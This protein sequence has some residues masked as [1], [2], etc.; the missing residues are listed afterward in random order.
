MQGMD[1]HPGTY[2][3][4]LDI[5]AVVGPDT[6]GHD[7]F[8]IEVHLAQAV[9]PEE[10]IVSSAF[11]AEPD[12]GGARLYWGHFTELGLTGAV[13]LYRKDPVT[14]VYTRLNSAPLE[15]GSEYLDADLEPGVLY[16]YKLGIISDGS[17]F[18]IGP[19]SVS[20]APRTAHL[21]QNVPNP[22]RTS[23]SISFQ[24]PAPSHVSLKIY[25]VG[26]RLVRT[27]KDRQ[28]VAGYHELAWDR[29]DDAGRAVA[30]GV[31]FC[32]LTTADY[33]QTRKM[34]LVQ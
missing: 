22:F 17:E 19:V 7:Y 31:Y 16:S 14:G 27:L 2:K 33:A 26:G 29:R 25:D 12:A 15:Q 20:G 32:R 34:I 30:S 9:G 11:G 21:S 5:W 6:V 23:T 10:E 8:E 13:N 4:R 18:Y 28:E 24:L 3:G 1:N